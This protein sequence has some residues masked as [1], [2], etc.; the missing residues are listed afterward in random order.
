[1]FTTVQNP[2][3]MVLVSHDE[4]ALNMDTNTNNTDSRAVGK[5]HY[6]TVQQLAIK[7]QTRFRVSS[8]IQNAEILLQRMFEGTL[9]VSCRV[10]FFFFYL[11]VWMT[12]C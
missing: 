5:T 11:A 7:A 1:V 6:H 3:N 12:F 8:K 9:Y 2:D 10:Q 4:V